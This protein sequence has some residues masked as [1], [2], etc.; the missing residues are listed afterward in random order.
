LTCLVKVVHPLGVPERGPGRCDNTS[1]GIVH[2]WGVYFEARASLF[3]CLK[4]KTCLRAEGGQGDDGA[5]C[6]AAGA[7]V[8]LSRASG[9]R[10]WLPRLLCG[11]PFEGGR[12]EP[13]LRRSASRG[14]AS[15]YFVRSRFGVVTEGI[16]C[17]WSAVS[18]RATQASAFRQAWSLVPGTA[19]N[20][21]RGVSP[22]SPA[23]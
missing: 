3:V 18:S 1:V 17:P 13:M 12:P 22:F 11:A 7:F 8:V 21:G 14:S 6:S 9:H 23:S 19:I 5:C 4:D 20:R 10:P 16:F 15:L 2:P